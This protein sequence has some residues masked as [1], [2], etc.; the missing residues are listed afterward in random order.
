LAASRSL[1]VDHQGRICS[2]VEPANPP[3]FALENAVDV[4]AALAV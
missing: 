3:A 1:E 4:D 2:A